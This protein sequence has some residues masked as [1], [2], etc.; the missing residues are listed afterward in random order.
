MEVAPLSGDAEAVA[1]GIAGWMRGGHGD[2]GMERLLDV[3]DD[4]KHVAQ[5]GGLVGLRCVGV[6]QGGDGEVDGLN[7]V[8]C[9][10]GD[11]RGGSAIEAEGQINVVPD[12]CA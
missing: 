4:V 3:A 11:A 9:S 12:G 6:L 7:D 1:A 8:E 2:G 10:G 5:A